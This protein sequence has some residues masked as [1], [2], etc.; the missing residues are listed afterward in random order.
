MSDYIYNK[1][2]KNALI[3]VRG[4]NSCVAPKTIR[5][6]IITSVLRV[7]GNNSSII[8]SPNINTS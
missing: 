6:I 2:V 8:N 4:R 3:R 7:R 5:S 1:P